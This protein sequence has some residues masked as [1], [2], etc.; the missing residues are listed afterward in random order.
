M[1]LSLKRSTNQMLRLPGV[2]CPNGRLKK[3]GFLH[4]LRDFIIGLPALPTQNLVP[5]NPQQFKTE[6]V[7]VEAVD[8][9]AQKGRHRTF[10]YQDQ[11]RE[12]ATGYEGRTITHSDWVWTREL[13]HLKKPGQLTPKHP[14]LRP[15]N[16]DPHFICQ[17]HCVYAARGASTFR[18]IPALICQLHCVYAARQSFVTSIRSHREQAPRKRE[19]CVLRRLVGMVLWCTRR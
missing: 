7:L 14:P 11:R 9:P 17:L 16:H 4:A 13:D 8:S 10:T 12:K 18:P 19:F 5:P 1:R 3:T 2:D 15:I 6:A